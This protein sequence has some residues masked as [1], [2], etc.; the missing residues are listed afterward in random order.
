MLD[1]SKIAVCCLYRLDM[2]VWCMG[3]PS[4]HNVNNLIQIIEAINVANSGCER[5]FADKR[6]GS[7]IGQGQIAIYLIY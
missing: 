3:C 7:Y 1:L 5:I 2:D 4:V 6:T